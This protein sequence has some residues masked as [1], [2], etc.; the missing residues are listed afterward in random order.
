ME[1]VY[2]HNQNLVLASA[3][4]AIHQEFIRNSFAIHQ[5]FIRNSLAPATPVVNGTAPV[6]NA[7]VEEAWA[8]ATFL[9]YGCRYLRN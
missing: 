8:K 6:A 3:E 4:G 5:E 1:E 7:R 2:G 9:R